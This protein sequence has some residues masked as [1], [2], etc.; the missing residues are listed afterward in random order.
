M[1]LLEGLNGVTPFVFLQHVL[2]GFAIRR[3][4][5]YGVHAGWCLTNSMLHIPE[6]DWTHQNLNHLLMRHYEGMLRH[7]EGLWRIT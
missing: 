3:N 1:F 4:A 7:Y 6:V 5:G 2:L